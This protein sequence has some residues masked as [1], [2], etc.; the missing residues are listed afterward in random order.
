MIEP[1][2]GSYS[3]VRSL[4]MVDFPLPLAPTMTT[5][6]PGL[7]EREMLVRALVMFLLPG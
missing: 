4:T 3:R 5:S 7:I 6:A 2:E 1:D